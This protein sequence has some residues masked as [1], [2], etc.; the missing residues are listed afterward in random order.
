MELDARTRSAP[1]AGP[2][3]G[4]G[5]AGTGGGVPAGLGRGPG[6]EAL[7]TTGAPRA[8]GGRFSLTQRILRPPA[9][10]ALARLSGF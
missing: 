7:P 6:R 1:S 9:T 3:A 10:A 4:R 8:A 2:D 5:A